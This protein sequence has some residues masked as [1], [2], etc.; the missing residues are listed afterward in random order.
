MV[1]IWRRNWGTEHTGW[2]AEASGIPPDRR[3]IDAEW[4]RFR[5]QGVDDTSRQFRQVFSS[6]EEP[7]QKLMTYAGNDPETGLLRWGNFTQTLLL[8]STVFD[9]DDTGRSYRLRPLTRAVWLRNLTIQGIPL[10]FFLVPDS[11]ALPA[12]MAGTTAVLVQGSTQTTNSWGLR[13]PEPD[14]AAPLRGIVLGD[15][16]MQGL[17][18]GDDQTP[19]ECLKRRLARPTGRPASRSSTP[20][21]SATRPSRSTTRSASTPTGS[22]PSSSSSASSPTTSAT[23]DE[24]LA[25]EGD[26][27]EGKYWLGQI[28]RVLPEPRPD[29]PHGLRPARTPDLRRGGSP[30]ITR[31]SSRTSSHVPGPSTATPS[32]IS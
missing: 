8:P 2:H 21:T 22:S 11:P 9:P 25:G 6:I 12:A 28:V 31:G 5:R 27:D 7:L 23:I 15:S 20:A 17:F 19:A 3:D 29:L 26:W 30:A 10:T 32:R 4:R 14:A 1:A 16:F 13:G 24:V 18:V